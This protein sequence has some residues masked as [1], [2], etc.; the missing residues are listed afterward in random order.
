MGD[1]LEWLHHT[2]LIVHGDIKDEDIV[3]VNNDEVLTSLIDFG[4]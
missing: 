4:I 3:R 2:L 1:T